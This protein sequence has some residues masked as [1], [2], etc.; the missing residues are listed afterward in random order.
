MPKPLLSESARAIRPGVFADLQAQ[1]DA[2]EQKNAAIA[3]PA[4]TTVTDLAKAMNELGASPRD[5]VSI[6]Q[7]IKTA[8]ALDADLEV[9]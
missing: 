1:I 7:A 3:L 2:H 5:L 9:F 4:A 8:G 6:L